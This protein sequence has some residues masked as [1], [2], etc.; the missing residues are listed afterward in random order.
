MTINS[1]DSK[2]LGDT[3]RFIKSTHRSFGYSWY[4]S[5]G[6][7]VTSAA[8]VEVKKKNNENGYHS[9]LEIKTGTSRIV[10]PFTRHN[11]RTR[12]E[13]ETFDTLR[14]QKKIIKQKFA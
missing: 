9:L 12:K 6:E 11:S 14:K 13:P 3:D 5:I 10:P 7:K 2:Y 1:L 8:I 4:G